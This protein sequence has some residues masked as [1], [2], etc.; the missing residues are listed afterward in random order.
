MFFLFLFFLQSLTLFSP[1]VV[2]LRV[3]H[4][5]KMLQS[6]AESAHSLKSQGVNQKWPAHLSY[7]KLDEKIFHK[8][9][10][11]GRKWQFSSVGKLVQP[12]W[13]LGVTFNFILITVSTMKWILP[14]ISFWYMPDRGF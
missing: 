11:E 12:F 9:G 2:N 4:L 13:N 6:V 5:W 8:Y 1:L 14:N 10:I 3:V 7:Q